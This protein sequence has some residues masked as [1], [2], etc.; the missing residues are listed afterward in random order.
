M[1]V[2][3]YIFNISN[4]YIGICMLYIMINKLIEVSR[5]GV[6]FL[7]ADDKS[8]L[9]VSNSLVSYFILMKGGYLKW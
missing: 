3:T 7:I 6:Y 4:T 5:A 2:I 1:Y 9:D 8:G